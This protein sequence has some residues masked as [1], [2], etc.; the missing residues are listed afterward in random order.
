MLKRC[1]VFPLPLELFPLHGWDG[2]QHYIIAE[3]EKMSSIDKENKLEL[4][5]L[6]DEKKTKI[7]RFAREYI[8]GPTSTRER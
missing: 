1:V 2:L 6:L 7:K 8:Q 4:D 3:K 5:T